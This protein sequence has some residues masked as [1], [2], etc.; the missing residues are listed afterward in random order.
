MRKRDSKSSEDADS[1]SSPESI[2]LSRDFLPSRV[3]ALQRRL[4]TDWRLMAANGF[5]KIREVNDQ[6]DSDF[7]FN[8]IVV[9]T[10]HTFSDIMKL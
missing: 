10:Y 6:A 3:S 4:G 1:V 9:M 2:A 8:V 5:S 7:V